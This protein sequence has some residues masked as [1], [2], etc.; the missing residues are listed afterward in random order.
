[1]TTAAAEKEATMGYGEAWTSKEG[2]Q[3][4]FTRQ[5]GT[6]ERQN[7]YTTE[8]AAAAEGPERRVDALGRQ[9]GSI[10]LLSSNLAMLLAIQ[11]PAHQSGQRAG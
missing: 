11:R 3:D 2:P 10:A 7:P 6:R 9:A 4:T 5:W 1:L 8:L